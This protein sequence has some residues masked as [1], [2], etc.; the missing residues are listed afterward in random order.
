MNEITLDIGRL[1]KHILKKWKILL[2]LT[3]AGALAFGYFGYSKAVAAAEDRAKKHEEYVLA[4]PELPGYYTEEL[5]SVRNGITETEALFAESYAAAYKSF[6]GETKNSEAD[7]TQEAKMMFLNSYKDVLSVMSNSQRAY[8]DLLTRTDTESSF[9]EHP[10]IPEFDDRAPSLLQPKWIILG[11]IVGALLACVGVG[12][13]YIA[14]KKFRSEDDVEIFTGK[15]ILF[16][17]DV[18]ND[19]TVKIVS[20]LLSQLREKRGLSALTVVSLSEN[21]NLAEKSFSE[22]GI[23]YAPSCGSSTASEQEQKLVNADEAVLLIDLRKA[24]VDKVK[25]I[26]KLCE[27]YNVRVL[28]SIVSK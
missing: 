17:F 11:M 21:D 6:T 1:L 9:T 14:S 13:P 18:R 22:H 26:L 25:H 23:I 20:A 15:P 7:H 4:A 10:V 3:I 5:Y 2:C 12:L 24:R 8:F 19:E 27:A 28:G 16:N